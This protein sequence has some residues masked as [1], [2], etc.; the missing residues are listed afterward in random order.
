[1]LWLAVANAPPGW[2]HIG[3][4][5]IGTLL[6]DVVSGMS[7]AQCTQ[8]FAAKM[9]PLRYQRPQAA[10]TSGALDRAEKLVAQLGIARSLER[11][12]ATIADLQGWLWRPSSVVP[13]VAPGEVFAHLRHTARSPGVDIGR[14][15][16]TWVKFAQTILPKADAIECT[17]AG[18][19]SMIAVLTTAVHPDAPPILQWDSAT[20]RNPV[21]WYFYQ[22]VR[23]LGYW[24]LQ[25]QQW[26]T[27][28]GI[29]CIPSSVLAHHGKGV[30][31]LV[32]QAKDSGNSGLGLFSECLRAEY[33]E[34]RAVIEAYSQC[35]QLPMPEQGA[36]VC[37]IGLSKDGRNFHT[38][39]R[40]RMGDVYGLFVL[41]R[42]D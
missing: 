10:P 26:Y 32:D 18:P 13:P 15:T 27:V 22:S 31:L 37:G 6:D 1:M 25:P 2:C 14:Q 11:R 20:Q 40:V 33:R 36:P 34:I 17:F 42:W 16:M 21:A 23:P 41:D 4:T 8:R 39:L 9:H 12:F 19:T 29:I 35:G 3:S 5:M 24:G 7:F 30:F 38:V 28:P